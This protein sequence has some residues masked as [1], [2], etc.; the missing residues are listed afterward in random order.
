MLIKLELDPSLRFGEHHHLQSNIAVFVPHDT[1]PLRSQENC[2]KLSTALGYPAGTVAD[3]SHYTFT[4]GTNAVLDLRKSVKDLGLKGGQ[5]L[6]VSL[7]ERSVAAG[8]PGLASSA[9]PRSFT[10]QSS[11]PTSP[12]GNDRVRLPSAMAMNDDDDGTD[13]ETDDVEHYAAMDRG[14][15][16]FVIRSKQGRPVVSFIDPFHPI[17]ESDRVPPYEELCETCAAALAPSD[18]LKV[19]VD[20]HHRPTTNSQEIVEGWVEKL[21]GSTF[22]R[23][24]K[25]YITITEKSID[26]FTDKPEL[27]Q[28][29]K[30]SGHR[31]FVRDGKVLLSS[32]NEQPG[33]PKCKE[34]G[35]AYFSLT[36]SDGQLGDKEM[37]FRTGTTKERSVFVN[38]LRLCD[39]RSK[40]RSENRN[41]V[42]WKKWVDAFLC[43]AA[44]LGHLHTSNVEACHKYEAEIAEL[45]AKLV[46]IRA[47][48]PTHESVLAERATEVASLLNEI[49]FQENRVKKAKLAI[50][51]AAGA[52]DREEALLR[53][54]EQQLGDEIKK[55]RMLEQHTQEQKAKL[56]DRKAELEDVIRKT[57]QRH[58]EIFS[59]WRKME[60]RPPSPM[61]RASTVLQGQNAHQQISGLLSA[62]GA[63]TPQRSRSPAH[64]A[65][66]SLSLATPIASAIRKSPVGASRS[67]SPN[68]RLTVLP[69][70]S[71]LTFSPL[72]LSMSNTPPYGGRGVSPSR[73]DLRSAVAAARAAFSTKNRPVASP[74]PK[75]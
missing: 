10:S 68:S 22:P 13:A 12:R 62:S 18:S 40:T 45:Q 32:I 6:L 34:E 59:K 17:S 24:Q 50:A 46:D 43:N 56:I 42:F 55:F 70:G 73:A 1:L 7:S 65:A 5:H 39:S 63:A 36:F 47:Q 48:R 33:H 30:I 51:K 23:W 58:D 19:V 72:A 64:V 49:T 35:F 74:Q 2:V 4:T 3:I 71:R 60:E 8:S 57:K 21:G 38:F 28:K 27:G 20:R 75:T 25:R 52:V 14:W 67:L 41:P 37:Y 66:A 54:K 44:D 29:K 61:L 9:T 26:W 31:L 11:P 69:A 15:M 53:A 16:P